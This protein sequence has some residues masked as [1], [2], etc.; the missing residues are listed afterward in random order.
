[1][2]ALS[3]GWQRLIS[4]AP[5]ANLMLALVLAL[6]IW[7]YL[8]LPRARDPEINFNW[9]TIWT[10]YPGASAEEVAREVTEPLE[11]ALRNVSDIR[12]VVS[13]SRE[14]LSSIL[15]RFERL[16]EQAFDKRLNDLRREVL[17]QANDLPAGIKTPRIWEITSSNGFPTA[18]LADR[19]AERPC[20]RQASSSN[21]A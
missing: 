16:D 1:M 4:N 11:D 12:Y 9:V 21:A 7:A 18:M 10:P 17:N 15:V 20:A 14:G 2:G 19:S 8:D 6:G 3:G 5:L 13:S